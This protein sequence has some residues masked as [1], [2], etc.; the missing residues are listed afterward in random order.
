M[1]ESR[2]IREMKFERP[3]PIMVALGCIGVIL[4]AATVVPYLFG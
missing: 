2:I 1:E 3:D 4:A